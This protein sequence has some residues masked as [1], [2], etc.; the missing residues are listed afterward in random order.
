L[1][2]IVTLNVFDC[3]LILSASVSIQPVF[4]SSG[5]IASFPAS[6]APISCA[7]SMIPP[8]AAHVTL[9]DGLLPLPPIPYGAFPPFTPTCGSL[10]LVNIFP[11][12]SGNIFFIRPSALLTFA[13]ASLIGFVIALLTELNVLR[14]EPVID[15]SR[16]KMLLI[17]LTALLTVDFTLLSGFDTALFSELK[18]CCVF[19]FTAFHAFE[20]ADLIALTILDTVDFAALSGRVIAVCTALKSLTAKFLIAFQTADTNFLTAL[21]IVTN[22]FLIANNIFLIRAYTAAIG[23]IIAN[24]I[25][26]HAI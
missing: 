4:L 21:K 22:T 16:L 13:L 23:F 7:P 26:S 24:L 6:P 9:N 17:L 15:L 1:T 3:P 5:M 10:M 20:T 2:V 11:T 12:L 14:T 19:F 8:R 18:T 25:P